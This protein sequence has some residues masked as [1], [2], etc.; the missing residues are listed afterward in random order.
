VR[1]LALV[2]PIAVDGVSKSDIAA[3]F[4]VVAAA[5]GSLCA[6]AWFGG[7]KS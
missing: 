7:R 5:C 2:Q 3:L 6:R 1:Y 4:A